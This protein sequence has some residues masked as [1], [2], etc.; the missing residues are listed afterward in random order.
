MS[1]GAGVSLAKDSRAEPRDAQ[2]AGTPLS[3]AEDKLINGLR[4][5]V[6]EVLQEGDSKAR[7]AKPRPTG[8]D[9]FWLVLFV[10]DVG[11]FLA[12]LPTAILRNEQV[13]FLGKVLPWAGSGAYVLGYTWFREHILKWSRQFWFKALQV[14]GAVMLSAL[15]F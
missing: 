1:P 4:A 13:E 6:R 3:A 2:E 10:A 11:L 9:A 7:R 14:T 12:W 5:I 15:L 8:A